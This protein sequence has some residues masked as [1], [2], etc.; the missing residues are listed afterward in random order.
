MLEDNAPAYHVSYNDL[1]MHWIVSLYKEDGEH[2]ILMRFPQRE[3][4]EA[5]VEDKIFHWENNFEK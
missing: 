3:Q 5:Y 2:K 1:D 4:A